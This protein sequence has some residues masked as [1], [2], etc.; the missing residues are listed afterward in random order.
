ML[1]ASPLLRKVNT[2]RRTPIAPLLTFLVICL[3]LM[4]FGY[5]NAYRDRVRRAPETS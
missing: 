5:L 4:T 3:A 2:G 1:P